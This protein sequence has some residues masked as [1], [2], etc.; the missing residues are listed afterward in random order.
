M[1]KGRL[2]DR[3]INANY[4]ERLQYVGDGY[5][6]PVLFKDGYEKVIGDLLP[7]WHPLVWM[8]FR[9]WEDIRHQVRKEVQ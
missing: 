8:N 5:F 2:Y 4:E 7:F 1:A 6:I 9:L 3:E